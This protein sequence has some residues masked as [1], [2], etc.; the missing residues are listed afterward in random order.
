VS[1]FYRDWS[2]RFV[3]LSAAVLS[4][5]SVGSS[6]AIA[7]ER[8]LINYSIL[9]RS[10]S[11][12]ALETYARDGTL[13]EDL[14]SYARFIK[15]NQLAQLREGL[16]QKVELSPVAISQFLYTPSGELLLERV[17]RL[18]QTRSGQGSF[19]ALRS[20]LILAAT[21]PQGLTPLSILRHYPNPDV[22]VNVEEIVGLV[23]AANRFL[24]QTDAV[25]QEIQTLSKTSALSAA[26]ANQL[27]Q[28]KKPGAFTW[29]KVTLPLQDGTEKRLRYT[30]Q[31]RQF[32]ADIYLPETTQPQPLVIISHGLNSDRQ[33]Y[34]YLAQHL[35]SYGFAVAVPEHP[36]S[37][38]QQL[39]ALLDGLGREVAEPLEF[40]DRPLDIQF[41]LDSLQTLAKTNV[42]FQG[43]LD[44]EKVG[45]IGQSFGGYTS[46]AVAGAPLSFNNLAQNCGRNLNTTLNISLGLQCQALRLPPAQYELADPR[47]K[48]AIAINPITSGVFGPDSLAQIKVPVMMVAGGRDI[49]APALTEQIQP[50]SQ[51]KDL[52][53]YL[54]LIDNS[55]HFSTIAPSNNEP[56]ALS[57]IKGLEGPS[58]EL[59]RSY[60]NVL[61]LLFM[62]A[63]LR[64]Q[65]GDT[66][67]L[68]P[69][70]A[71]GLSQL[72]LPLS[73]VNALPNQG[74]L[75]NNVK[76]EDLKK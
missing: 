24:K 29:Q 55:N 39:Q 52:Q 2:I 66:V 5:G 47:I 57:Q 32:V 42:Q 18:V 48:A 23:D 4:L 58:P 16:Q 28:F 27:N 11:V 9:G 67:F 37:N 54:V 31:V 41:L 62:Q 12:R 45:I 49:V 25:T 33:S 34:A 10:I 76:P 46:L 1:S 36:G 61:G 71:E 64:G 14:V 44:F 63:Y 56:E 30:G 21:D 22:V 50:F 6:G 75:P 72:P 60:I 38:K 51:L 35:A 59:A 26:Q 7:A 43:K 20:A 15:P 73:I 65:Q 53:H 68:S 69:A 3:S 17:S 8:L 13:T 74:L 70:G 19:Y 40:L